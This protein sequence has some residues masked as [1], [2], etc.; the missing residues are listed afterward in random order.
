MS[1]E[2]KTKLKKGTLRLIIFIIVFV[3]LLLVFTVS[4]DK[5]EPH[6]PGKQPPTTSVSE[7]A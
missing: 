1:P 5:G 7:S 4:S 2:D 3:S 6:A